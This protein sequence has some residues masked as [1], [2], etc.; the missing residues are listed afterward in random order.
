M[1]IALRG[2][3]SAQMNPR[4]IVNVPIAVIH[5]PDGFQKRDSTA[6]VRIQLAGASTALDGLRQSDIT[7]TVDAAGA[8][9]GINH[10]LPITVAVIP[11][12]RN[13]IQIESKTPATASVTLEQITTMRRQVHIYFTKAPPSGYSYGVP[14]ITP[15]VVVVS[16]P[17]SSM[18][19]IRD[20]VADVDGGVPDPATSQPVDIDGKFDVI[21]RDDEGSRISTAT[22]SPSTVHVVI[23]LIRASSV[24]TVAIAPMVVGRPAT[25]Y[26]LSG[27]SS[28]PA[29]ATITGAP[30]VLNRTSVIMTSAVDVAGATGDIQKAT[31]LEPP[32]GVSLSSGRNVVV[33]VKIER[34][35]TTT[36]AP[37]S[38]SQVSSPH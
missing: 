6:S 33:T 27:A 28:E 13:Q 29:L 15:S 38:I 14:V 17:S 19:S 21:A 34:G 32:P 5:V 1:A 12:L 4:T 3:V 2:Y 37:Q 31:V 23:P 11:E 25:G 36:P 10:S 22:I 18:A 8:H 16:A 24:K 26:V 35:E 20:V 30:D 7:A 9:A